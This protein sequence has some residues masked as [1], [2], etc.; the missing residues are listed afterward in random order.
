MDNEQIKELCLSLI[1]ADY[2]EAVI[3]ILKKAG[4]WDN[5]TVWRYYGD[6]ENNFSTIGNQQS[7]PDAALIEKIINSVDACLMNECFI[8]GINP[9]DLAAPQTIQQAVAQFYDKEKPDSVFAGRI[10][11]WSD[12][13]RTQIAR[14]ITLTST[15]ASARDGNP[16]FT[17]SDAGEGQTPEMMPDT[18][19]SLNKSNKI[20]I[21]FVQG[22]FNMGGTGVLHFCGRHKLQLILSRRNPKIIDGES[23]HSTDSYWGFTIVRREDPIGGLRSAVYKYLAPYDY[24]VD[25]KPSHGGI[26]RFI[27]EKMPIFPE[28]REAYEREAAW[29]TLIKLYEY[30]VPGYRTHMFLKSGLLS[31]LDLLLPDVALPIRLH[32]C[33][34]GYRG[35]AG[36]FET[37]LTGIGVRLD[38]DKKQN[39]E[40]GFPT[41]SPMS[42]MGQQMTVTIYAFKKGKS[43][44]YRKNEGIIFTINGQTHGYLTTDFFRR[45]KVGLSYLR[46]SILVVIDCT[47]FN[48]VGR[49]DLFMNSRDRLRDGELRKEIEHVLEEL[50]KHH[51]NLRM[52]KERRKREEIESKLDDDRPLE[53]ILESI[54]KQ[55]PSLSSLFI[56]GKR[57]S[58]PFKTKEVIE[59]E[60]TFEGKKHPTYFKFKGKEY[61][62]KLHRECHINYRLRVPFETDAVND[63]FSRN[64]DRGEFSLYLLDSENQKQFPVND[65]VGPNLQ[66]GIASLT[67]KLPETCKV[68]D[69]FD[70]LAIVSDPTII[71]PFENYF[72]VKVKEEAE[73]GGKPGT[74]RKPPVDDQGHD[75]ELPTGIS[76]PKIFIV[77]EE[78]WNDY[79]PPFNKNTALRVK[80]D[81]TDEDDK[82]VYDFYINIDNI[83]LKN[84]L[85]FSKLDSDLM[86]ARF[87][88]GMV[89]IGLALLHDYQESKKHSR[90]DE[91]DTEDEPEKNIEDKTEEFTRAVAPVLIPMIDRLGELDIETTSVDV[92][93]GEST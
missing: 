46:D 37:T 71:D 62:E 4:F 35:H 87:K 78:Q 88:Y 53:D 43:E 31:R 20:R 93:S 45:E 48:E 76:L 75:R 34:S 2:E 67:V 61:G 10:R 52:L 26:L 70:Y 81:I 23:V 42:V 91:Q 1:K 72:S 60:K 27:A 22:K 68:G 90:D 65:F 15:G 73:G 30:S 32:E 54:L 63:Y 59:K 84:E 28:G 12:S 56:L 50:L 41:S 17:I 14:N 19:L 92:S 7:K 44:S 3:A 11:E 49:A 25:V 86:K 83:H 38:D 33:R 69:N 77:K 80:S 79:D 16:C 6:T 55:S 5:L 66:N 47:K 13:K 51:E 21:P 39:L 58:T 74:R 57:L 40:D 9:E 29:G 18:F 8:Q 85:K 36:S 24:D 89:L 64:L 82:T